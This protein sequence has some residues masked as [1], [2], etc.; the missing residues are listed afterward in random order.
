MNIKSTALTTTR[1]ALA[2]ACF[3]WAGSTIA[4]DAKVV[5]NL[6]RPTDDTASCK[7][8]EWHSDLLGIYPWVSEGCHA[9]VVVNGEKW[10]RFEGK[11]VRSN[12]NGTF[13]TEFNSQG[14]RPLGTVTMS[15]GPGQ[16][17]QL[18]GVSTPFSDL[19]RDQVLSFYVPE[20]AL[21]FAVKPGVPRAELVQYVETPKAEAPVETKPVQ[22]AAADTASTRTATR[23]PT[24]AGPLPLFALGGLMS[25]LGGLGLSIRRKA[26]NQ[27]S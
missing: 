19:K 25:M 4:Q 22:L 20:G 18:D 26:K 11:F 27:I 14:N 13:D 21:G 16:R 5:A 1:T 24:T 7:A 2:L 8:M 3:V 9:V 10:A 12:N 6:D 23:L 15:P 17:M